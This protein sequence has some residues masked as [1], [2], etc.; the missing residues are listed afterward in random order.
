[1]REA[2]DQT[3]RQSACATGPISSMARSGSAP[4]L[5]SAR[6]PQPRHRRDRVDACDMAGVPGGSCACRS[7]HFCRKLRLSGS[8]APVSFSLP[9]LSARSAAARP[10][11][12][13]RG[14]KVRAR[15][16]TE[17]WASRRRLAP[18]RH[19]EH[20]ALRVSGGL[21]E[22]AAAPRCCRDSGSLGGLPGSLRANCWF[23]TLTLK[24]F[25]LF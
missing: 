4:R 21:R 22:G 9:S 20:E 8:R 5:C 17:G 1:M 19:G 18:R 6:F 2:L 10:S 12:P 3:P 7:R 23:S 13:L 25:A 24:T 16:P 14:T 11:A 15:A